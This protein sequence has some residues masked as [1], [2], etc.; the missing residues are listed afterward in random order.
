VIPDVY[1]P[2]RA[3]VRD[4]IRFLLSHISFQRLLE[5][6][7]RQ[8]HMDQHSA[9]EARLLELAKQFPTLHKLG[10]II[11]RNKNISRGVKAWLIQLE[12]GLYGTALD[13]I[14]I[15]IKSRLNPMD[16]RKTVQIQPFILS[17]ASVGAVVPFKLYGDS[18]QAAIDGVFKVLKPDIIKNLDEEL[19]I[20]EKIA[21]YFEMNRHQYA[22]KDFRFLDVFDQV[23]NTLRK[24]VD[25]AAEQS[26]LSE[27]AQFFDGVNDII[28]PDLIAFCD[29]TMTAMGYIE[30]EKITDAQLTE[31]QRKDCANILAESLICRPLFAADPCALFHGDP[32]AGNIMVST[33]EDDR[34]SV[35]IALLDWSLAGHLSQ[36][37]RGKIVRLIK[38][39]ILND[40]DAI[41]NCVRNIAEGEPKNRGLSKSSVP[42]IISKMTDPEAEQ[43]FSLL[44]KAF[45]LLE[46]VSYEGV[47]FPSDLMLFRKAIFT[48]EGVIFDIY[49]QFDMDAFVFR[50]VAGLLAHEMPRRFSNVLFFQSDKAENYQS[51]LSSIDLQA[52]ML[53][54]YTTLIQ[55]NTRAAVELFEKQTQLMRGFFS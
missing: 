35:K 34:Q 17:E 33:A 52:L 7:V 27:A 23:S 46:E 47:V 43:S 49:P 25:L 51:H 15:H 40:V 16:V 29:D 13:V 12:N 22:F 26:H 30:G 8:I 28:I 41:C 18:D 20:F 31:K 21:A 3:L 42:H 37:V 32:H 45:R 4:G 19:E 24:E 14:L 53:Q 36:K 10:Q 55:H 54:Q 48:L 9:T 5:V 38:S 1:F 2:Y 39:I 11:A 6:M 50:Y 44:K